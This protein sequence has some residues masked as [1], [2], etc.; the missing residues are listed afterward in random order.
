VY[1]IVSAVPTI[2]FRSPVLGRGDVFG[3]EDLSGNFYGNVRKKIT[4]G[5]LERRVWNP[6]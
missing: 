1:Y 4:I 2:R 3:D 5:R 6:L